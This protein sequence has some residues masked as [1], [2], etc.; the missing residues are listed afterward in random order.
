[1]T[2]LAC[3]LL[4]ESLTRGKDTA[5]APRCG[6][7][8][9]HAVEILTTLLSLREEALR[10]LAESKTDAIISLVEKRELME[11][12]L[13]EIGRWGERDSAAERYLR[14]YG[15]AGEATGREPQTYP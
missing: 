2:A 1:L 13:E 4:E 11:A 6:V 15:P 8:G 7:L 3:Y 9:T 5:A 14:E 12:A 10:L